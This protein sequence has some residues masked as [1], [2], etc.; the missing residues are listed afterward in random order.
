[1]T[2][3]GISNHIPLNGLFSF[4]AFLLVLT[5][6]FFLMG[7][8]IVATKVPFSKHVYR[9]SDSYAFALNYY[10]ENNKLLEPSVLWVIEDKG[11]K[12]VSEFSGLYF[13]SSGILKLIL[14]SMIG[15]V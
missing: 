8:N 1:M 9:Q 5:I 3:S 6:F 13:T 2:R 7:Y 15:G 12:A 11:G 14:F 4:V 10:Y